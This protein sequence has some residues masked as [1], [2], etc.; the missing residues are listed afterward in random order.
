MV[1]QD[2]KAPPQFEVR[3]GDTLVAQGAFHFG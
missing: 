2:E 1:H 3:Q